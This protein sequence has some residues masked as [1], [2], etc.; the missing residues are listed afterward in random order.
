MNKF[1]QLKYLLKNSIDHRS[2]YIMDAIVLSKKETVQFTYPG[3][4]RSNNNLFVN[5]TQPAIGSF[6]WQQGA[7]SICCINY[8]YKTEPQKNEKPKIYTGSLNIYPNPTKNQLTI[9]YQM[10]TNTKVSITVTDMLGRQIAV[11][12]PPFSDHTQ[13]CYYAVN[14]SEINW[15]TGMYIIT[16]SNGT[17][18]YRSQLMINK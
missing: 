5:G 17:E 4:L 8:N 15:S 2:E 16:V 14:S 3:Q 1:T 9:K 13:V 18:T 11:W 7:M 10:Q 12:N 6:S